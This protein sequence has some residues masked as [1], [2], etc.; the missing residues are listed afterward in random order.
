MSGTRAPF[1][2]PEDGLPVKLHGGRFCDI[3]YDEAIEEALRASYGRPGLCLKVFREFDTWE[4]QPLDDVTRMQ[5]IGA[6]Y[7]VAPRVY[8]IVDVIG[9]PAQVTDYRPVAG[10][11][12]LA[13]IGKLIQFLLAH[14]VGTTKLVCIGGRAK[15][16]V[17]AGNVNWS[18]DL[19]LDWGGYYLKDPDAY[20]DGLRRRV[21]IEIASS[22]RGNPVSSTY[23]PV[24]GITG[25]RNT[26]HRVAAMHLGDIDFTGRTVLD[27]GAN[28]GAFSFYA[29]ERDAL[30]VTAVDVPLVAAPMREVGNWLGYWNIDWIGAHL[31]GDLAAIGGPFDI[32]LALS[33]CNHVHGYGSWIA[34][35]C[36]DTLILEGHGGDP[37]EKYADAL[38]ADFASVELVGYTSDHMTRPVFVCRKEA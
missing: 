25:S 27:L 14:D 13:A 11:P 38:A 33:I 5:N 34:D 28:L 6:A 31:P 26:P 16:D 19:F 2:V 37:P 17:L 1:A 21:S 30:R 35:L 23:Q 20:V 18:D 4:G 32:V 24:L 3:Y 22:R 29:H 15:W 8:D 9:R 10:E 12:T 7:G 36:A